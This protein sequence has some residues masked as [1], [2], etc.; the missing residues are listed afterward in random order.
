MRADSSAQA[1]LVAFIDGQRTGLFS[2]NAHGAISF[3]YDDDLSPGA[4]RGR[5]L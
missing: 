2:Q 4:T 1:E 5:A 3:T